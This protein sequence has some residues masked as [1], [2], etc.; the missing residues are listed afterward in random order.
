M[1]RASAAAAARTAQTVLTT[2]TTAFAE[3][4]YAGVSLEDIARSAGVTRGA[5]YHHFTNK[6]GLFTAVA[7]HLQAGVAAAVVRAAQDVGTA[8]TAQLRA[9][10]HGFLDAITAG[11]AVQVLLIDAPAVLGWQQWRTQDAAHSGSHLR[12][13]LAS[14]GVPP[15]LREATAVQLSG[16]MNEA[17]LWLAQHLGDPGAREA[18]HLVL[19]R[20][21]DSVLLNDVTN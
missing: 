4:G 11:P 2:A 19:D 14:A 17:A 16:A 10:S 13:A 1:A 20:L 5:I 3:H 21:L 18:A 8:A 6:V 9:G 7:E 15:A 12:Q